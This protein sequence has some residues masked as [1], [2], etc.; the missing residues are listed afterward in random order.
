MICH[1]SPAPRPD[2]PPGAARF[3]VLNGLEAESLPEGVIL[4]SA[5]IVA[6]RAP[7]GS[8]ELRRW[9]PQLYNWLAVLVLLSLGVLG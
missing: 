9:L 1:D 5:Y 8:A 3:A 2:P 6:A 7:G 4:M